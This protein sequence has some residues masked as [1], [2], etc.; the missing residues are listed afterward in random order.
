MA[1]CP[2]LSL[3]TADWI[4]D[5]DHLDDAERGRFWMMILKL[6]RQPQRRFPNDDHW[7]SRHF[8]RPVEAV[9]SELRPLI[10]DFFK[11]DG[12]WIWSARLEKAW[13]DI[14]GRFEAARAAAKA[15]WSKPRKAPDADAARQGDMNLA[16]QSVSDKPLKDNEND[17]CVGYADIDIDIDIDIQE[18]D[19]P[20]MSPLLEAVA[21]PKAPAVCKPKPAARLYP[22]PSQL[23]RAGA[24]LSYPEEFE[25]VWKS[26]PRRDEDG[27][28]ECYQHWR[29]AVVDRKVD[30]AEIEDGVQRWKPSLL[31]AD[32]RTGLRRWLREGLWANQAPKDRTRASLDSG[33][34]ALRQAVGEANGCEVVGGACLQVPHQAEVQRQA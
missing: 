10:R 34:E 24:K 8:R 19:S 4:A 22:R 13:F 30:P 29:K 15:R 20:L 7:L 1:E 33:L 27:K 25:A 9:R 26:Y 31:A 14:Q 18:E 21:G 11:T 32:Y 6:W 12:N 2:S 28:P 3:W 5:T 16:S 17:A 23:P